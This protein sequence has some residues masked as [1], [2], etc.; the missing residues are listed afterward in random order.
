[1]DF[2][3]L[4]TALGGAFIGAMSSIATLWIQS[5][6]QTSA[7]LKKL[8]I[9]FAKEDFHYRIQDQSGQLQALPS[10]VLI[11]YYVELISLA[12]KGEL[13]EDTMRDLLKKQLHL[14]QSINA[15]VASWNDKFQSKRKD[16]N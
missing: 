10:S 5:H 7:E 16:A 15:E 1:M 13:N 12:G 11:F 8:A 9:E 4:V 14:S 6:Y 2:A 3:T